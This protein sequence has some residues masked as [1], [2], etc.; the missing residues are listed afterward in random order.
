M[1]FLGSSPFQSVINGI[2]DP[3]SEFG[4]TQLTDLDSFLCGCGQF[5][6][7][8]SLYETYIFAPLAD[9]L[10]QSERLVSVVSEA[11]EKESHGEF[12]CYRDIWNWLLVNL[13]HKTGCKCHS[14]NVSLWR[15]QIG[16]KS[17]QTTNICAVYNRFI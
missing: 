17:C 14:Q 2:T 6:S 9:G 1:G 13:H 8:R 11:R 12:S 7:I 3:L 5:F 10:K 15:L 16:S 4:H